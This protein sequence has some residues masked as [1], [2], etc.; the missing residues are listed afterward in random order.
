MAISIRPEEKYAFLFTGDVGERYENDVI[1]VFNTLTEFYGY[2]IDHIWVVSGGGS[3]P[4]ATF[5]GS[6]ELLASTEAVLKD[7]LEAFTK[8][9]RTIDTDRP[10]G[11]LNNAFL[12]FTGKG[13]R[14]TVGIFDTSLLV[15]NGVEP[16]DGTAIKISGNW[17]KTALQI[18]EEQTAIAGSDVTDNDL[19]ANCQIDVYFEQSYGGGFYD[20]APTALNVLPSPNWSF[21]SACS[22][23]ETSSGGTTG[24][25]FTDAWTNGLKLVT[26]S[27][28]P[29]SGKYADELTAGTEDI[30]NLKV[31][32]RKAWTYAKDVTTNSGDYSEAG[33]AGDEIKYL[34]LPAFLI[35]DGVSPV[36]WYESPDI[37]LT[38]P[39]DGY[40]AQ[41]DL[42]HESENNRINIDV[43]NSGTHPVRSFWMGHMVFFSGGGGAGEPEV[44][45]LTSATVLKSGD[46]YPYTY[47]YLFSTTTHRCIKAKARLT[48]IFDEDIDTDNT[49]DVDWHVTDED[50][51]AQRNLDKFNPPPPPP[52]QPAPEPDNADVDEEIPEEEAEPDPEDE[53]NGSRSMRNIRG[54]KEHIYCIRNIFKKPHKFLIVFPEDYRDYKKYFRIEWF[55]MNGNLYKNL[56]ALEIVEKPY[57]H[58]PVK[59]EPGETMNILFYLALLPGVDFSKEI[60]LPFDI[61]V[62]VDKDIMYQIKGKI[63]KTGFHEL[64]SEYAPFSGITVVV[65]QGKGSTIT[66]KVT[67]RN[68]KPVPGS[69]VF[70]HTINER[71][72]AVTMTNK[73]GFYI[74]PRINCDS[75]KLMAE[76]DKWHTKK[77]TVFISDGDKLELVF[78]EKEAIPG[79]SVKVILD[80]IRILN[81]H[82]PCLKGKGELVFTS[83]VSVDDSKP[84]VVRLPGEGVYKVSD[85]AGK[86][87]IDLGVTIF[88]GAATKS[89]EIKITGRELDKYDPD[90]DLNRYSRVFGGDLKKWYGKY[91][92]GDEYHD[93][94]DVGDWQVW[95]RIVR[96]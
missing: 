87:T 40:A 18:D 57:M 92:P 66:G 16:T 43:K 77:K 94:E 86:N 84:Q 65:S 58:I 82:D 12:Y 44:I 85:K 11:T 48:Q 72:S 54:F 35:R 37:Y 22:N 76:T 89:L 21:T 8:A 45:N 88:E 59:L 69:L 80:K 26:L 24:S 3:F 47:D 83:F 51:E 61:L 91:Y 96:M 78:N 7:A 33:P 41:D 64:K 32:L 70:I 15:I 6:N 34:G 46:T 27:S 63:R 25:D 1:K 9:A 73:E 30:T 14:E 28:G 23:G 60:R 93:K 50:C 38:H 17:L 49:D 4:N 31:S 13:S 71:Q 5:P 56:T 90:D 95:Y 79:K 20:D 2:P 62:D 39:G 52:E 55:K 75:Y 81:D 74:M 29:N 53:D 68:N 36:A 10:A 19:L 42:Y 67:D